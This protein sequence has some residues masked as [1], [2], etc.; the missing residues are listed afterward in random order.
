MSNSSK[1]NMWFWSRWLWGGTGEKPVASPLVFPR[2]NFLRSAKGYNAKLIS[3]RT[4]CLRL[5]FVFHSFRNAHPISSVIVSVSFQWQ[6]NKTEKS[7][8]L[9]NAVFQVSMLFVLPLEGG[10]SLFRWLI[11]N[12][13]SV[14]CVF[15]EPNR[16]F[17]KHLPYVLFSLIREIYLITMHL[18]VYF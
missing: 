6:K 4:K 12:F 16:S 7:Y 11:E 10:N 13:C 17:P 14:L 8:N 5:P 2:I 3:A 15:L 9:K 1:I 18:G